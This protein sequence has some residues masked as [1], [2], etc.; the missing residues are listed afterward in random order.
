[1][2]DVVA[3]LQQLGLAKYA[4]AFE[5]NEIDF[6]ALSHLTEPRLEQIGLPIGP[7]VKLLAA[8]SELAS[9]RTSGA[10]LKLSERAVAAFQQ[11]QVERRQI[12]V[13]FCDLIDSTELAGALD[14]EDL[15]VV[16]RAYQEKCRG[17]IE[18][19]GGRVARYFGDGIM[20]YFG[21]PATH[22]DSAERGVR[23]GLEVVGAVKA[24]ASPKPLSVRVGISTGVVVIGD[25]GQGDAA[26]PTEAVGETPYIAARLQTLAM[27]DSVVI[28]E[29]TSRLISA[30]FERENLGPR[31]LKGVAEPVH[32]FRVRRVRDESIRF[33]PTHAAPLTPLVGRHA[34]LA[35]L[36]QRWR[37]ARDGEGQVV[38]I[39]GVPGIGKSRL[40][41]ELGKS[42]GAEDHFSLSFQCLP[43]CMQS[44][45]FPITQ[46][47]RNLGG[48]TSEDS[49]EAKLRKIERLLVRATEEVDQAVPLIAQMLSV[50]SEFRYG[51]LALTAQQ[52]KARTLS[53][54]VELLLRLAAKRPVFCLLED[55]QWIDPSTQEL[56]DLV[57]SQLEKARA[58]LV[59]THRPEYQWRS[60]MGGNVSG[61]TVARLG[62]RDVTT[63][64]QLALHGQVVST[65]VMERIINESD[66]IPLFVEEL[67]R[68]IIGRGDNNKHGMNSQR[69]EPL[70]S[71]LVPDSLRDSLVARLDRAPQARNV[72]QAAAVM[73]REFSYDMLL[74]VSSLTSSDLDAALAHLEENEIVQLVDEGPPAHYIFKHALVRDAAYE[75]LLKSTRREIHARIGSVIEKDRP[76][77]VADQPELLAYHYSSAGNAELAVRYWLLG[78]QHA[79]SRSANL[80]A[81]YQLLKAL[82]FIELLPETPER[83]KTELE[84]HL[85]LGLCSIAVQGYSADDARRSFEIAR[86]LCLELDE[87]YRE[88]QAIYGLWGHYWMKAHHD[89]AVELGETLLARAESLSDPVTLIIGHRSIGST[90]FTLGDF[91]LAREHL[92]LAIALCERTGSDELNRYTVNPEIAA[93]L[94]LAWDLWILGYPA[95]ALHHA[96]HALAHAR[97]RS[98]PYAVAFA[99]YV[100]SAVRLLRGEF[101]DAL[102]HADQSSA[103]S[104]ERRLRLYALYSQFGRGCALGMMGHEEDGI[105]E[106]REGIEEAR[107]SNLGYMRAFMLGWLATLQAA[108]E[109]PEAALATI[110]EAFKH[111]S[112]I[113]GRA[114][115][116]ELHRLRGDLLLAARPGAVDEA[117]RSYKVA[118]DVAQRQCALSLELR[119]T[120][121]LARLL[122]GKGRSREAR[123]LLAPV[124][125]WFTEGFDTVDLK[126]ARSLLS[127]L[128]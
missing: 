28:A 59:V 88:I 22:E 65:A 53:M 69:T 102:E 124:Y 64:T 60:G 92:E 35:F 95:K 99:H 81:S 18:H 4:R 122:W 103:V 100:T 16:M 74:R 42:I 126:E 116:A 70:A 20:A 118:I 86:R 10:E 106:V 14:P 51:P 41:Y 5:E 114:W 91:V 83:S 85:S 108:T 8:I 34:E 6:V 67:A 43:H 87:P 79:R 84:I 123:E 26:T 77:I 115:E 49:N 104:R 55:A 113:A 48:L 56:L 62:H 36:Q 127:E 68:G 75:C 3:W 107:R 111:I 121:S 47:V 19:Y 61:L 24:L 33:Q 40:V 9:S 110:D 89:R 30:R 54:L 90:R 66:A 117:E 76:E 7:R 25:H 96:L 82:E 17:I 23:A 109:G 94:V 46:K 120:T 2:H 13:M 97:G 128:G 27:P 37:D 57:P 119:A 11:P 52:I 71:W 29:T 32:V 78:G 50:P 31:K 44:A 101:E 73:G 105:V 93:E 58:L 63:M 1:M 98:D 125:A 12:T 112:D 45:L 39:S 21:W 72:V 38:F 15:R 80:E